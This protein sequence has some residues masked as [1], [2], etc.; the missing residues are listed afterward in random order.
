[1]ASSGEATA[2]GLENQGASDFGQIIGLWPA[3]A[4][5]SAGNA[6]IAYKDVHNGDIQSDDHR[7]ADL[8]LAWQQGG[9]D[10]I[11]IDMGRG[12]GNYTA[13]AID[14]TDRA[15]LASYNPVEDNNMQRGI[16]AFRTAPRADGSPMCGDEETRSLPVTGC[17]WDAVRLYAGATDQGISVAIGPDDTTHIA[18]YRGDRGAPYLA[19]LT[20]DT[21]FGDLAS[22][23]SNESFGDD[24]FDEGYDP[25]LAID[26]NGRVA[27]VYYR[28]ALATAGLG[29]CRPADDGVVFA[30]QTAGGEWEREVIDD[31]PEEC[32]R[33]PS[34][35]FDSAGRAH[36]AYVCRTSGA[37]GML[38]D[39]VFVATR[40]P[41]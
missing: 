37:G 19:T 4:F 10:H 5:D 11:P 1:V 9:W 15:V 35:A 38:E 7:I 2:V 25:A 24:R 21:S 34:L 26:P 16:Y 32:G 39:Q 23:W 33:Y 6:A 18:Y 40:E 22:G 20:D 36:V 3:L 41:L 29:N 27:A 30:Y 17:G 8:E 13:I 28:C 12:T 14:G 31:S